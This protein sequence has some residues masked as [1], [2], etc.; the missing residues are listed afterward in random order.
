MKK[1][2]IIIITLILGIIFLGKSFIII[3]E[4]FAL[5]SAF[6]LSYDALFGKWFK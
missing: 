3:L 4:V 5:Y 1:I 2:F 6:R